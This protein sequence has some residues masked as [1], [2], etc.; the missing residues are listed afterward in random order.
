[1][2]L[3]NGPDFYSMVSALMQIWNL[4]NIAF[5]NHVYDDVFMGEIVDDLTGACFNCKF[6]IMDSSTNASGWDSVCEE[7]TLV[8]HWESSDHLKNGKCFIYILPK[9]LLDE[10]HPKFDSN[11]IFYDI[12]GNNI[13]LFEAYQTPKIQDLK[14]RMVSE[15]DIYR[16]A[17]TNLDEIK[18]LWNVKRTMSGDKFIATYVN[19]PALS[20]AATDG[21]LT[22]YI[23]DIVKLIGQ[24]LNFTIEFV[25]QKDGLW[26]SQI[27]EGNWSGMVGDLLQ[28]KADI[29]ISGMIMDEAR[30]NIMDFSIPIIVTSYQLIAHESSITQPVVISRYLEAF[31]LNAWI[32][33]TCTVIG[34]TVYYYMQHKLLKKNL[35]SQQSLSL[36]ESLTMVITLILQRDPSKEPHKNSSRL[37]Y[38]S[39]IA[40]TF[41][42]YI[43]YTGLLTASMVSQKR[44]LYVDSFQNLADSDLK[45]Y[46]WGGTSDADSFIYSQPGTPYHLVYEKKLKDNPKAFVYT[47]DEFETNLNKDPNSVGLDWEVGYGDA[48]YLYFLRSFKDTVAIHVCLGFAKD[49]VLTQRAN[50]QI[51]NFEEAGILDKLTTHYKVYKKPLQLDENSVQPLGYDN[52]T[53]PFLAL[54][55]GC[56]LAMFTYIIERLRRFYFPDLLISTN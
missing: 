54:L 1:M 52:L 53:F 13:M 49:S 21:S 42:I 28:H 43:C 26:G 30:L 33:L 15:W 7:K 18:Y 34:L 11:I 8:L 9:V 5:L 40:F 4:S 29:A 36:L 45:F 55:L 46:V 2:F 25:E 6:Q 37:L 22:G 35:D 24:E 50:Q 17:F 19:S 10:V 39:I 3:S 20:T 14:F 31:T 32:I 27:S 41:V 56:S 47:V 16:E 12:Q 38:F 44:E 51:L 48:D 23:V